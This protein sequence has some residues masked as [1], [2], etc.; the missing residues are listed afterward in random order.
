MANNI[1]YATLFQ[2]NLDKAMAQKSVT[3]WMESNAGQV[4]YNGGNTVKIPKMAFDGLGNYDR[5]NGYANGSVSLEY[6]T[7]TMNYDRS[8]RFNIDSMD[9]DE[10]NFVV[11]AGTV[12]SEFQRLKVVPEVDSIRLSKLAQKA[13]EKDNVKYGFAPTKTN[14]LDEFKDE[15]AKIRDYGFDGTI[16]CHCTYDFKAQLEKA[17]AGQL[18]PATLNLGGV[19]T[20]VPSIDGVVLIPTVSNRLYTK[21]DVL[22]GKTTGQEAGG[23]KKADGA[24]TINFILIGQSVPIAISKTERVKTVMPEVNQTYDGYSCYY[25]KYHDIWVTDNAINGIYLNVKEAKPTV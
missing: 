23:V 9:V 7:M 16:V 11:T 15:V 1:N 20:T 19:D 2:G 5:N 17:F 21:Y 4:K 24:L 13:I 22:D 3:G 6:E 25:R 18:S 14:V 10:S 12:M 8:K